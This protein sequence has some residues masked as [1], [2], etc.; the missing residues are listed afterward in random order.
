[1][2]RLSFE[3]EMEDLGLRELGTNR[4]EAVRETSSHNNALKDW[5]LRMRPLK[6][7]GTRSARYIAVA[8]PSDLTNEEWKKKAQRDRVEYVPPKPV[9]R[10][11]ALMKVLYM[12]RFWNKTTQDPCF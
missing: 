5:L 1:M 8:S 12:L 2:E 4:Y 11:Y 7:T 6:M 10:D 9:F 3:R